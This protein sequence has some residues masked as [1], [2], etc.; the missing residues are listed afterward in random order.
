MLGG[1]S[2]KISDKCNALLK[3]SA[4]FTDNSLNDPAAQHAIET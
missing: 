3:S 4:Q 2:S 1:G